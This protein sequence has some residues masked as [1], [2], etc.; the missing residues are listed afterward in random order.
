VLSFSFTFNYSQFLHV[1]IVL[2]CYCFPIFESL[3]VGISRF[4][5]IQISLSIA[6]LAFQDYTKAHK[7]K[8]E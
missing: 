4:F 1:G 7:L 8:T 3:L 2:K 6:S 5:V